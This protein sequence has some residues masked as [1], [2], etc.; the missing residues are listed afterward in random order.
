MSL[1][2][3]QKNSPRLLPKPAKFEKNPPNG[4]RVIRKTKCGAGGA[5]GAGGA[6]GAGGAGG[7]RSSPIHKQASLAGRLNIPRQHFMVINT[8][9]KLKKASY[10]ICFHQSSNGE[11]SLYTL[12]LSSGYNDLLNSENLKV[13]IAQLCHD[14][15]VCNFTML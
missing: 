2:H 3:I 6:A 14:I 10:N 9:C 1:Q 12:R 13:A 7:A 15:E 11:I 4:Y 5:G 8:Y